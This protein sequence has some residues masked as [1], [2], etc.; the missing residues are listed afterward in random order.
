MTPKR[1]PV[2]VLS[3]SLGVLAAFTATPVQAG[4]GVANCSGD[5]DFSNKLVG[6]GTITFDCG[7]ATIVLSSTKIIAANT[8]IDGG[9]NITL[10]GDNA[11]RLFVVNS[12]ARLELQNIVIEQ[13]FS[14]SG[15]GGAIRNFDTLIIVNSKFLN[16]RTSSAWSGGAIYSNGHLTISSSGFSNNQGGSAG[17]IYAQATVA[18][19]NHSTFDHNQAIDTG[20]FGF[21][22]ALL[23]TDSANAFVTS[24]SFSQN[25]ARNGGAVAVRSGSTLNTSDSNIRDNSAGSG[26]AYGGGI[27]NNA[28]TLILTNVTLS[29]NS[30]AQGGGISTFGDNLT[31]NNVT[32]SGNS[33][34]ASGGGIYNSR[35]R[36]ALISVT[37]A[38]NSSKAGRVG[39]I[40]N[41]GVGPDPHL[42][43][44]NVILAA[45]A[46]G[47]NCGFGTAPDTSEFNLS[48]DNT[49]SFGVGRDNVNLLLWPLADNGGSTQTHL[50]QPGSLVIDHGDNTA[51]PPIDQRGL[52]RSIGASCDVGAVEVGLYQYLPLV[53]R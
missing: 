44:N 34:S 16:N 18:N 36:M 41:V 37:L 14:D 28:G 10:S 21:G 51:C 27:D 33:A 40:V 17:A 22:G 35:S 13:G 48:D 25:Q 30:G 19:I 39:G 15:D 53:L 50:P 4:G 42:N 8:T 31:L 38:G 11:R 47:A 52:R 49:C 32:L 5:A 46:T 2:L 9:G 24:S 12:G 20:A 6:G 43:L 29:G 7:A 45:G 1:I 23:L 3:L 26:N